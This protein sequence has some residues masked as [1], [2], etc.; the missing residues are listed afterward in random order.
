MLCSFFGEI[1]WR[2]REREGEGKEFL[3]SVSLQLSTFSFC[4]SLFL[5][6][7]ALLIAKGESFF[8]CLDWHCNHATTIRY[9]NLCLMLEIH[10]NYLGFLLLAEFIMKNLC[11]YW[12]HYCFSHLLM[13]LFAHNLVCLKGAFHFL[14]LCCFKVFIQSLKVLFLVLIFTFDI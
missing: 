11:F 9:L 3:S 8:L 7:P 10:F 5:F 12:S 14:S 13:S 2:E 6:F 4:V 1:K